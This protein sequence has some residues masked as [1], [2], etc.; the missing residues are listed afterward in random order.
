MLGSCGSV[1]LR[2]LLE[3]PAFS[4]KVGINYSSSIHA[5]RSRDTQVEHGPIREFGGLLR[6]AAGGELRE[7]KAA[8]DDHVAVWV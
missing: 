8:V 1:M 4:E 5:F 7:G 3:F 6:I 2:A